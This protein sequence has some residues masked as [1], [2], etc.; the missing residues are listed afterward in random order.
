MRARSSRAT[1][2][3]QALRLLARRE[4]SRVELATKLAARGHAPEE[5]AAALDSLARD[6]L[7]SDARY[8]EAYARSRAERGYG[9]LRIRA[10]LRER[11]VDEAEIA[12]A[13]AGLEADWTAA[14]A[15]VRARRFGDALPEDPAG[16]ARQ[17]RWLRGRGF[18]DDVV[19]GV[20]RGWETDD[21]R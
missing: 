14:A 17:G 20:L 11:G 15:A 6:G 12:L 18:P 21:E 8:A 2:R 5:V 16:R 7:Q 3:A 1:A 13:L 19:R 4:H 9:P 10:E